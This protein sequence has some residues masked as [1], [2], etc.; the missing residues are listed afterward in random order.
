MKKIEVSDLLKGIPIECGDLEI[1]LGFDTQKGMVL[2]Q[3]YNHS[4][5]RTSSYF[6]SEQ[7]IMPPT[8]S[9]E[10]YTLLSASMEE[11]IEKGK[12]ISVFS[13]SIT[14]GSL[15]YRF[16][17]LLY[18]EY[19]L[20]QYKFTI[21]NG[22][23][24]DVPFK[25][26]PAAFVIQMDDPKDL[27]TLS[28]F[29]GGKAAYDHGMRHD[30]P[31][32]SG[33]YPA[34][35]WFD[36]SMTNEYMPL[37]LFKRQEEPCD[38]F[39][40]S[41]DYIG[42]WSFRAYRNPTRQHPEC[43]YFEFSMEKFNANLI[44]SK[45]ELHTPCITLCV[46]HHDDDMLM[47]RLY[48][49]QYHSQWDYVNPNYF[50]KTRCLNRWVASS[51]NLTEQFAHCLTSDV[52]FALHCT[53]LGYDILWNDA[54][55]SACDS[56]PENGYAS[57]FKNN[58][59]GPDFS[60]LRKFLD[61]CGLG[62]TLWF[63]GKPSRSVLSQK[64]SCWGAF[65]WRTDGLTL[66]TVSEENAF[67]NNVEAYLSEN[68]DR[69][70]HTCSGGSA[71]SHTFGINRLSNYN[72]LADAGRGPV[73]TYNFSYFEY[74]DKW[75]DI[76]TF[77]GQRAF[78]KDG[79]TICLD[80]G[81]IQRPKD[82]HYVSEFARAGLVN[83][84]Y[85]GECFTAEDEESV[86][87]DLALYRY[88]K[89]RG[90]AGRFSY[91]YH[92]NV[93]GDKSYYY[94]QRTDK[95]GS[96][97]CIILKHRPKNRVIVYPK[98]L[99]AETV[100]TVS[101]M[102]QKRRY[103][104]TG[105]ALMQRGIVLDNVADGELIFL[106]LPD[107]PVSYEGC[108][109]LPKKEKPLGVFQ[110]CEQN[111][112]INGNALYWESLPDAETYLIFRDGAKIG[113]VR[114]G[115]FFFDADKT[116]TENYSV[117]AIDGKNKLVAR[118]NAFATDEQ[119][120]CYSALGAF[121]DFGERSLWRAEY[122]SDLIHF[123]PMNFVPPADNPMA[124]YGG[125]PNQTGGIEGWYEAGIC[126]RVGHGF[127]QASPDVYSIRSF[128]CPKSGLVRVSYHAYREW[129]HR[130]EGNDLRYVFLHNDTILRDDLIT[131]QAGH[132]ALSVELNVKAGDVL[133]FALGKTS[134]DHFQPVV[135]EHDA[136][137]VGCI[138]KIEYITE[139]H[140]S[141]FYASARFTAAP[142]QKFEF[143]VPQGCYKVCL[144]F[145]EDE[146][147]C[148]DQRLMR[149]SINDCTIADALD[150]VQVSRGGG[151]YTL[152]S[153]YVVPKNGSI[154]IR[155]EG[156]NAN[157]ILE[158]AEI[159]SESEDV[160]KINCGSDSDYI[161]WAGNLWT[162]D[163]R[164]QKTYSLHTDRVLHSAPTIYDFPLYLCGISDSVIDY[165]IP[166]ANGIYYLHL[167]FLE[168]KAGFRVFINDKLTDVFIPEERN[169]PQQQ[170]A[171][172]KRYENITVDAQSI[173]IRIEG[174]GGNVCLAAIE[175]GI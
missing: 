62:F 53:K 101:F 73:A 12:E 167:K 66:C 88:F 78:M 21:Q 135:W 44:K 86:A 156:S 47:K 40:V 77:L 32:G 18:P 11:K 27:Y 163:H 160:L 30:L 162:A 132:A 10:D 137:L 133:R 4:S 144:R 115:N 13:A 109:Q 74:P 107:H 166:L 108:L 153:R 149:V 14:C 146:F 17:M 168:N 169:D 173:K 7:S 28:Y 33:W 175:A 110:R 125:T 119:A 98:G 63:A 121:G 60:V 141:L 129:Y 35:V 43:F 49:W 130:F 91:V 90:I 97:A 99:Q 93:I 59:E 80:E 36:S 111:G 20:L 116:K 89:K 1:V 113:C 52:Q 152:V 128:V 68:A 165:E 71:Y 161:D 72:Y 79:A 158:F 70:F 114:K 87:L 120:S 50:A 164:T 92:P 94:A 69:S 159:C 42:S 104:K 41:V 127:Q 19:S 84:P 2:R 172:D 15:Q 56:W 148:I 118:G 67:R 134:Q 96:C 8:E 16:F 5:A 103:R 105:A 174:M 143:F 9:T 51:R 57:V 83:I 112:G 85:P 25:L 58:Y 55:W 147:R 150:I 139:R 123:S 170:T 61:K 75:G 151:I 54:G 117:C 157:A 34:C 23:E 95:E 81:I 3:F 154:R 29:T 171:V 102:M 122:S 142:V 48:D 140:S 76:L 131:N 82:I 38:A 64:E 145:R 39:M 37:V 155:C 126:A 136:D 45:E 22:S 124:D 65:E 106:N 26:R 24:E 138:P 31:L 100:Y 6:S 46:Y